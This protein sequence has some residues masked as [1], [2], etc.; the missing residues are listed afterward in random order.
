VTQ[1]DET[2]Q[3]ARS[4]LKAFNEQGE[5]HLVESLV[6]D[7]VVTHFPE[8]VR[9]PR[10]GGKRSRVASEVALPKDAFPDQ[11]FEEEIL[12]AEDDL[13][14]IAWKLSATHKGEFYGKPATEEEVTVEG[15]DIV[16]VRDGKIAEHWPFYSKPRVHV[17]ARLGLLDSDVA[18]ELNSAGL[19]R[20]GHARGVINE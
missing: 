5:T 1:T 14:F 20:A 3:V 17:L 2:K 8:T 6:T 12:V 19:L 16:R 9:L 13:A 7:D 10:N 18:E 15:A 11:R 4:L